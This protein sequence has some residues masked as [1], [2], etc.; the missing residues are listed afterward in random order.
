MDVAGAKNYSTLRVR[1]PWNYGGMWQL[2]ANTV[3]LLTLMPYLHV[4]DYIITVGL[5]IICFLL[6]ILLL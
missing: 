1:A 6:A 4:L 2:H 3:S 5:M